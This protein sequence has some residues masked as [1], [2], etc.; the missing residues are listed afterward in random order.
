MKE[1]PSETA[2]KAWARLMRTQQKLLNEIEEALATAKLPALSWY[3]ALLELERA[4][5]AGLRPF[6]LE[7]KMLLAQYNLSRLIDRLEAAGYIERRAAKDDGRGQIVFIT[8]NGKSMRRRM[9]PIYASAIEK[10]L[11]AKITEEEAAL[12]VDIL[13]KLID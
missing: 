8:A 12:M 13:G 6:E 7:R 5:N 9:W 4:G 10:L 11:G 2:V 1:K 3:D